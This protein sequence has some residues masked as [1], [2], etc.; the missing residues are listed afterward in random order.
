[1]NFYLIQHRKKSVVL[2]TEGERTPLESPD[3]TKSLADNWVDWL[4]RQGTRVANLLKRLTIVVRE[5][6]NRLEYKI[7]PMERVF[8]RMRHASEIRL[9]YASVLPETRAAEMLE[10]TLLADRETNICS[11]L[12]W[13]LSSLSLRFCSRQS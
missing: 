5:Y 6:Y 8:K 10:Q 12:E 11:G 9:H 7:D 13:I 4:T 1:M 2:Y 3:S